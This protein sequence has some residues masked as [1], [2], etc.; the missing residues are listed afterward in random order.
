MVIPPPPPEENNRLDAL[1]SY[2]ILDSLPEQDYDDI[3]RLASEICQTPIALIS[4]IDD[5]RQWFKSNHGL[6]VRETPRDYAFCT[7]AILNPRE[8]LIVTDSRKDERF[9]GNP[10]VTGDPYVIFYAGIPLVDDNGFPLGSLCVIDNEAKQLNQSQLAALKTLAK[11]V[12][13]LLELRKSNQALTTIKRLLEQR[14]TELDQMADVVNSTIKPQ[15][16]LLKS[17]IEQLKSELSHSQTDQANE[18]LRQTL[19]TV[20]QLE[21]TLQQLE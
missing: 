21:E 9:A 17:T 7:H 14:N 1:R 19:N 2:N 5:N 10:L 3:T 11:Q 6:A 16:S 4:L 15:I 13:N 8:P 20:R 12:V 18:L